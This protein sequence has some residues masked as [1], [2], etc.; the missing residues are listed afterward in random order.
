[1]AVIQNPSRSAAV[2]TIGRIDFAQF[3]HYTCPVIDAA[4][5]YDGAT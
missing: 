3:E 4:T 2:S 1:M 5:D